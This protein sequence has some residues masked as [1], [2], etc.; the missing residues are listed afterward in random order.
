MTGGMGCFTSNPRATP[1]LLNDIHARI[2]KPTVE[3][4]RESQSPFKGLLFTGLMITADGPK[5]L[6]YNVRFG[7][8]ETEALLPLLESDLAKIMIACTETWL[9][10][11]QIE[12]ATKFS[13]TV[14]AVA[15]GYPEK[16]AKGEEIYLSQVSSDTMIFHSGTT[17][18]LGSLKTAGGRVLAVTSIGATLSEAVSAAYEGMKAVSYENMYYRRDIGLRALNDANATLPSTAPHIEALTY[19]SSGV[20]VD[21]GNSFVQ[22]I[23]S[24]VKSTARSGAEGTIGGFGGVFDLRKAG[25][26]EL[27]IIVYTTDGVGTKLS[28]AHAMDK[29]D[30]IGIDC[31]AMNRLVLSLYLVPIESRARKC[32][33]VSGNCFIV[34]LALGSTLWLMYV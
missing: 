1:D 12:I 6:E 24:L 30:T 22:R 2:L 11:V 17:L 29:H 7:D 25:F 3:G 19:A 8:P 20:S 5:V 34:A 15:G 32:L 10:K 4:M 31:V 13:T 16:Y 28:I 18:S 27:P 33:K 23:K 14:I 21:A 26:T 9:D